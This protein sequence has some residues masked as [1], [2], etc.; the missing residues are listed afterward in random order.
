M[1]EALRIRDPREPPKPVW[2]V[3]TRSLE[4]KL[5]DPRDAV[6]VQ[7]TIVASGLVLLTG[8][9][10]VPGVFSWPLGLLYLPLLIS[11]CGPNAVLL[12]MVSHRRLFKGRWARLNSYIPWFHV[13]FFGMAPGGYMTHH[14][15]MHHVEENMP[16]DTSATLH[17]RRDSWVDF[18]V[19]WLR[20]QFIGK[21]EL[22]IY[23][24][25]HRRYRLLRRFLTG[26][27]IHKVLLVSLLYLNWQATVIA[28][29]VPY[30]IVRWGLMMGNW[31][32]HA[33]IDLADPENPYRNSV[34]L[35]NCPYN[36][37]FYN[38]GYH[39]A[40]HVNMSTHWGDA[41]AAFEADLDSYVQNEAVVFDGIRGYQ[42]L[43][44]LLMTRQYDVLAKHLVQWGEP[45]PMEERIKML[46]LRTEPMLAR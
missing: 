10:Y 26:E 22:A 24:F 7:D 16:P 44:W 37:G 34:T 40:H 42:T 41:P 11:R 18:C 21:F 8:L 31:G 15:G 9:L 12:H 5:V 46:K 6:L 20:F 29:I 35:V 17:Y 1:T 14:L 32:Q 2:G 45:V 39:C 13:M 3:L 25:R 27:L 30:I 38:D 4:G 19:Y 43:W 36:I 33:F 23:L 28:F